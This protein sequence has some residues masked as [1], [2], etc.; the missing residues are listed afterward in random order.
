MNDSS[1]LDVY[2][3]NG[4]FFDGRGGEPQ[5]RHLGIRDGVVVQISEA[6]IARERAHR[7]IVARGL[8]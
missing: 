6:P 4:L 5:V 3:H 8:S 7:V 1:P 2:I